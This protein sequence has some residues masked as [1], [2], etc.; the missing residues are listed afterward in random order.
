LKSDFGHY[1]NLVRILATSV[2]LGK[3]RLNQVTDKNV[4][5]HVKVKVRVVF[6]NK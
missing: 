3:I 1:T 2:K 5:G 6:N 4:V